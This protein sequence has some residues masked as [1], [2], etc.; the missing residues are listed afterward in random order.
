LAQEPPLELDEELIAVLVAMA[1]QVIRDVV[2]GL[3]LPVDH[4]R[5]DQPRPLRRTAFVCRRGARLATIAKRQS[6]NV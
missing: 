6:A 1:P 5:P 4:D 2:V 3:A